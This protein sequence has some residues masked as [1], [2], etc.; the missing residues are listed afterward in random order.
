LEETKD[1]AFV[2][3][4][5]LFVCVRVDTRDFGPY[6]VKHNG[7][8]HVFLRTESGKDIRTAD[9]ADR[10]P[11][12]LTA[13]RQTALS[14]APERRTFAV[15]LLSERVPT[16]AI[17]DTVRRALDRLEDHDIEVRERRQRRS[18]GWADRLATSCRT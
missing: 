18:C 11:D 16:E 7:Y 1:T 13:M 12:I 17:R 9:D 3:L 14:H 5:R 15:Y 2:A 10:L 8:P 4:S 6:G